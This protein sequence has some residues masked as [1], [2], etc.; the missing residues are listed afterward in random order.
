[1]KSKNFEIK[2]CI[3]YYNRDIFLSDHQITECWATLQVDKIYPQC[4]ELN[5][6]EDELEELNEFLTAV[7]IS[8]EA[9]AFHKK[10]KYEGNNRTLKK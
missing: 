7:I 3:V 5:L 1:M 8:G 10:R 9:D 4:E 6:D 2:D